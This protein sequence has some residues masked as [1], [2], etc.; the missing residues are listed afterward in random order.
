MDQGVSHSLNG[1]SLKKMPDQQWE[2]STWGEVPQKHASIKML[3]GNQQPVIPD[4]R[5]AQGCKDF[6]CCR[7]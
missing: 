3:K 1:A 6:T 7:S 2:I 4:D 5:K